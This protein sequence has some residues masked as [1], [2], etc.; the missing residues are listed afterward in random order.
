MKKWKPILATLTVVAIATSVVIV[1]NTLSIS[2]ARTINS[3]TAPIPMPQQQSRQT[4]S[5]QDF[6]LDSMSLHEDT[7]EA[8]LINQ[9]KAAYSARIH[10]LHVQASLIK[11][12]AYVLKHYPEDG[13]ERF[14]RVI[15]S[16]FPEYAQSILGIIARLEIYEEWIADNQPMLAEQTMRVQ[17]GLIWEVRREL[18]GA[19]A[20]RIWAE[21]QAE[22]AQQQT[23]MHTFIQQLD[24]A[25]DTSMEE[26]LFQLQTA[27]N[28]H[29][30]GS[31]QEL[32]VSG[33][34]VS[35]AFFNLESVQQ[36]LE[37]LPAPQRQERINDVRRQL[38]LND[39]QIARL[40]K[41]DEERNQRWQN[42]LAYMAERETLVATV[43]E[44]QLPKALD[45]LREK[46]FKHEAITIAKEEASDFWRYK[47][48]RVYG[49]N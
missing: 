39:E 28:E 23:R 30:Q 38:G 20:E 17:K 24:Q 29:Y 19:D 46:Y 47:R 44:E 8:E 13:A 7:F 48:R 49:I 9:L 2:N 37:A 32:A 18:F 40:Q 1:N 15:Q 43:S 5:S 26:K 33:G 27:I 45:A 36:E 21:E 6:M 12:K 42:G 10:E 25:H 11:V 4:A 3:A 22:M 41:K 31:I 16:A 14:A 34:I 35:K